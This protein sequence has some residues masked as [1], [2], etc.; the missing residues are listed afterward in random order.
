MN[1]RK[2]D[3]NNLIA[4]MCSLA[5][6]L[7]GL[8]F[9]INHEAF[10]IAFV[11]CVILIVFN[12]VVE[13]YG[14]KQYYERYI[15]PGRESKPLILTMEE[16]RKK[17]I[18]GRVK[19]DDMYGVCRVFLK[20]Y[21]KSRILLIAFLMAML[22][23]FIQLQYDNDLLPYWTP[24]LAAVLTVIIATIVIVPRERKFKTSDE[25]RVAVEKSGFDPMRVNDDFML[26]TYHYLIKGLLTIGQNYYVIYE[27]TKCYVGANSEIIKVSG[28]II[29]EGQTG[30]YNNSVKIDR[31]V[32]KIYTKDVTITLK[33]LDYIA[34]KYII[35]E[36]SQL[37]V[38]TDF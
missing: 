8:Y 18:Y 28:R 35:K 27:Q 7:A 2:K 26:G 24:L 4:G 33:C 29:K 11:A 13:A 1:N 9:I 15:K 5:I 22:M 21:Y 25:L 32:L 36:F 10:S 19:A 37:G 17:E 38:E 3:R 6:C 16:R 23:V 31:Y 12:G 30:P 34:L 20:E 14:I